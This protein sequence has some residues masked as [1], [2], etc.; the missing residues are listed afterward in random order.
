MKCRVSDEVD[1]KL[2]EIFEAWGVV[3]FGEKVHA[4]NNQTFIVSVRMESKQKA[5]GFL[6]EFRAERI[7]KD[8]IQD[9][10]EFE[11]KNTMFKDFKKNAK[12][13]YCRISP[14]KRHT[15]SNK[16]A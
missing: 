9:A 10:I 2:K 16:V 12:D 6:Q 1:E 7:N 8:I 11:K 15:S 4:E 3:T 5:K 14:I 13:L